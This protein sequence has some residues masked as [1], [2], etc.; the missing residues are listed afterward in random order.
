VLVVAALNGWG[1]S[2]RPLTNRLTE[3]TKKAL[4]GHEHVFLGKRAMLTGHRS[5]RFRKFI[6]Q[7]ESPE[8]VLLTVSKSLGARNM[9]KEVLNPLIG[10]VD[11]YAKILLLTIDPCWP[12]RYD[13]TPNLNRRT[14]ELKLGVTRGVNVYV[15]GAPDQQCGALL[16]GGFGIENRGLTKYTHR[17]ITSSVEVRQALDE[18]IKE[19]TT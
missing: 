3:I 2:S 4:R 18:M 6:R 14:L 16:S 10:K 5:R 8:N 19:A 1:A 13:W 17:S 9:V 12:L 15:I 7:Y 11:D